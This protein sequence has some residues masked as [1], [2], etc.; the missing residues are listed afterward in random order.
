MWELDS[1]LGDRPIGDDYEDDDGET[2]TKTQFEN[3]TGVAASDLRSQVEEQNVDFNNYSP[4]QSAT[5][6]FNNIP[7][8]VFEVLK[9]AGLKIEGLDPGFL[10]GFNLYALSNFGYLEKIE[11]AAT[12]FNELTTLSDL[13]NAFMANAKE[14]SKSYAKFVWNIKFSY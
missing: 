13:S 3:F 12:P 4:A 11:L 14:V 10:A 8:G 9:G 1:N 5:I 6:D 7:S 2:E